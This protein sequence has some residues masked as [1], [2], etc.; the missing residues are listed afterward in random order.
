MVAPQPIPLSERRSGGTTR[1]RVYANLRD[2]IV[3]AELEPGRQ[4][5]EN[6]LAASLGVSRTPVREALVRLRDDRLVEI[7][8]QLGTFVSPIST[9][10]VADA[11]FI[12]EALECAA[13]RAAAARVTAEDIETLEQN[14][15]AQERARDSADFDAFYVLDDAFHQAICDLS[16]RAVWAITQRAK[17]HLNRI[18]RLSLPMPSYLAE[19]IVEHRAIVTRLAEQDP[20][21][22]E[23]ALRHHLQMV[24]REVPRIREQHPDFFEE[25]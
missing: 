20:D 13:V 12:R 3:R 1:A 15:T 8:P 2:A 22:A 24:L 25:G 11:Q 21:G 6:E 10:A 4:L 14:L 23:A 17:G 16:G 7:V 5:S 19:M 9:R 18:R